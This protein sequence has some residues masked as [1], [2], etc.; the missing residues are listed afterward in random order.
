MSE[1]NLRSIMAKHP[2]HDI[3][4]CVMGIR[5]EQSV[6]EIELRHPLKHVLCRGDF[7]EYK[8]AFKDTY[9]EI[10]RIGKNHVSVSV[11]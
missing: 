4:D 1:D 6:A 8:Y 5:H 11:F 3:R 9:H 10:E 7:E 2:N